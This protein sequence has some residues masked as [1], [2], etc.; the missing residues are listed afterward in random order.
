M[1]NTNTN[2]N[3]NT[4]TTKRGAPSIFDSRNKDK[5][6]AALRGIKGQEGVRAPSYDLQR[7]LADAGDVGVEIVKQE[8]RGRPKHRAK[9]TPRGQ[10]TVN[11]AR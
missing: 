10:A 8:G 1:T 3:T 6:L 5:L 11:F 7:Q 2:T 9:L 4:A